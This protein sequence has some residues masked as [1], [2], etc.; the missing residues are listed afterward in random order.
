MK[1]STSSDVRK[2]FEQKVIPLIN[3]K[4]PEVASE[5]SIRVD[6]AFGLG[7]ADESSNLDATIYLE[8]RLWAA[9][10]GQVQLLLETSL[11]ERLVDETDKSCHCVGIWVHPLSWLRE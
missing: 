9:K 8:D 2:Y 3:A 6:G 11:D 5:M 1:K 10:G 4:Y 7:I